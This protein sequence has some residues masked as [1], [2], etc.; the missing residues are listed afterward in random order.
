MKQTILLAICILLSYL[1]T[2]G[3]VNDTGD[4]VGIGNSNPDMKLSVLMDQKSV[5]RFHS[6]STQFMT[7]I[8]IGKTTGSGSSYTDLVNLSDGFG[9]GAGYSGGNLPLNT[10]NK[11]HIAIYT[12]YSSRYVGIGTTEPDAR[13]TVKGDIHT[14]EVKVDLAGAV[15]PDFVF[16]K[17]YD[18]QTLRQVEEYIIQNSHLPDVPSAKEMEENGIEFKKMNLKLLQKVEELTL[19]LIE[20]DKKINRLENEVQELKTS[21]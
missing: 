14:R 12:N 5:S 18:L 9:I 19:Y 20:Q 2:Y 8:R 3:Q 7:G 15:A 13:L 17:D 11:E 16:K 4:K 21:K 10:Q 6:T 1:T